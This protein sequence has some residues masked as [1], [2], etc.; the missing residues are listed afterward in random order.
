M[1][2]DVPCLGYEWRS[3]E[4]LAP[5]CLFFHSRFA[6]MIQQ[7]EVGDIVKQICRFESC[8]KNQ[9]LNTHKTTSIIKTK[10]TTPRILMIRLIFRDSVSNSAHL[11]RS[12]SEMTGSPSKGFWGSPINP[13]LR[14]T[15]QWVWVPSSEPIGLHDSVLAALGPSRTFR[16]F[17]NTLD[18][19]PSLRESPA[20]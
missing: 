11:S 12:K 18:R 6:S 17:F 9:I 15:F 10:T 8:S 3:R 5:D 16:S 20:N 4:G 13:R 14:N 1:E 19:R 7:F 2:M